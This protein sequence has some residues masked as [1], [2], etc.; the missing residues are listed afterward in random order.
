[1]RSYKDEPI[2][3]KFKVDYYGLNVGLT[4]TYTTYLINYIR[5]LEDIKIASHH[6]NNPDI[7][8]YIYIHT[9]QIMIIIH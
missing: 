5:L 4:D 2:R 9:L 8:I 7:Y 6:L 3:N 1:M